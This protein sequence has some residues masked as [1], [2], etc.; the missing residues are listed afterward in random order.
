MK[1]YKICLVCSAGGHFNQIKELINPLIRKSDIFLVTL[2]REDSMSFLN[3]TIHRHYFI[4][5]IRDN[6]NLLTNIIDSISVF[7]KERP[8]IVIT[9]GA[10]AAMATCLIAK[11]F[12]KKV[13]FIESFAR[14]DK[15]STFGRRINRFSDFT[16]YQW[17]KLGDYY[18]NRIYSGSIFN[19]TIGNRKIKKNQVFVTVGSSE[20]QFNRLLQQLD[21]LVESG[22]IKQRVIAQIGLSDYK[23]KNYE[24]FKWCDFSEMQNIM[25]ESE[26][27]IS[28]S[29]TGSIV[30]ALQMGTKVIVVPRS[31][32]YNEHIDNHQ[33]EIADEF[34]KLGFV[35][36]SNEVDDLA[37]CINSIESFIPSG[38]LQNTRLLDQLFRILNLSPL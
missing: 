5:D 34:K 25:S 38:N 20:Y 8:D 30:N 10:G 3:S 16:L 6:G 23:P 24:Y 18:K 11:L 27:V 17:P 32:K 31:A 2:N 19:I 22:I 12:F 4:R 28:H 37:D 7:L 21:N 9:T 35:L 13:I 15:P 1:T 29:G 36:V 26:Y 33:F 14:V